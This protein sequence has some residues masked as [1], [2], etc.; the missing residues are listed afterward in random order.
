MDKFIVVV[1]MRFKEIDNKRDGFISME[2]HA[3]FWSGKTSRVKK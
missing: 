1:P 2:G 3:Y